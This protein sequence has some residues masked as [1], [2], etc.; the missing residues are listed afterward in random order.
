MS[1]NEELAEFSSFLRRRK[2]YLLI[3]A[4]QYDEA[5]KLLRNMLDEPENFDFAKHEL[6]FLQEQKQKGD[7]E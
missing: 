3:E 1:S 2:V 6:T 4:E 7:E 5:E